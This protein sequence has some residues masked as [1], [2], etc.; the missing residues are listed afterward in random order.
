[1]PLASCLQYLVVCVPNAFASSLETWFGRIIDSR[2]GV[3]S[4]SAQQ[5]GVGAQSAPGWSATGLPGPGS[6]AASGDRRA[7]SSWDSGMYMK[8][9][10]QVLDTL[11]VSSV[12]ETKQ[13]GVSKTDTFVCVSGSSSTLHA[14]CWS[15][16]LCRGAKTEESVVFC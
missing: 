13:E 7:E 11:Q 10:G 3:S 12:G 16:A 5:G 6:S 14:Q 15:G 4:S 9:L 8:R 2:S 1:V